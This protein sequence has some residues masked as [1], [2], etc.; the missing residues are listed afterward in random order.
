MRLL[1]QRILA[2]LDPD[3][4]SPAEERLQQSHRRVNLNRLPDST[5]LL[6][7]QLTPSCQAIWKRCRPAR[8][9]SDQPGW[10]CGPSVRPRTATRASCCNAARPDVERLD[11]EA[12]LPRPVWKTALKPW[13]PAIRNALSRPGLDR[14]VEVRATRVCFPPVVSNTSIDRGVSEVVRIGP[15]A[16][17]IWTLPGD[18]DRDVQ[19]TARVV[20]DR[21]S[22]GSGRTGRDRSDRLVARSSRHR[23]SPPSGWFWP[24]LRVV[25]LVRHQ[26]RVAVWIKVRTAC[27]RSPSRRVGADQATA[28]LDASTHTRLRQLGG[29]TASN[30]T[31]HC[32]PWSGPSAATKDHPGR[33]CSSTAALEMQPLSGLPSAL[34]AQSHLLTVGQHRLAEL[35][36]AVEVGIGHVAMCPL[37]TGLCAASITTTRTAPT[38]AARR[39]P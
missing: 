1:G 37:I 24:S 34:R 22:A 2:H 21:V 27:D 10:P 32:R 3:G 36:A 38:P 20:R 29:G 28:G 30:R 23:R 33:R 25:E 11:A 14:F 31:A 17:R 15:A 6:D 9:G 16:P 39:S 5:G 18:I 19:A 7:G 35:G 8:A 13:L 12:G 26:V 4:P